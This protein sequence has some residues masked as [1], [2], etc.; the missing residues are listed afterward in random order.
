MVSHDLQVPLTSIKGSTASVV[1]A[2]EAPE[3]AEALQFLGS[4]TGRPITC[5]ACRG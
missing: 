2:S 4:S 1:G 3:P 5:A